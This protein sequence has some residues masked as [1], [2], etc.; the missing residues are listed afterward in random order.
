MKDLLTRQGDNSWEPRK[1]VAWM[2][3][4]ESSPEYSKPKN[5]GGEERGS[6]RSHLQ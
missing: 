6:G 3:I 5:K 2:Y 4:W 1:T